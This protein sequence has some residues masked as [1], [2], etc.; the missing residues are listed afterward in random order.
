MATRLKKEIVLKAEAVDCVVKNGTYNLSI[1]LNDR[2]F[3]ALKKSVVAADERD[4]LI[5]KVVKDAIEKVVKNK[6]KPTKAQVA[7]G[8]RIRVV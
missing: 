6:K 2:Q 8:E 4:K 3:R 7:A 5:E 1:L